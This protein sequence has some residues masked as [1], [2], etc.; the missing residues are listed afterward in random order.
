M[1]KYDLQLVRICR[2]DTLIVNINLILAKASAVNPLQKNE[3][4]YFLTLNRVKGFSE[5]FGTILN[6]SSFNF[7]YGTTSL[8]LMCICIKLRYSNTK[9][10]V[11]NQTLVTLDISVPNPVLDLSSPVLIAIVSEPST[12]DEDELGSSVNANQ[13]LS[14]SPRVCTTVEELENF[15]S[16]QINM[17]TPLHAHYQSLDS[18]RPHEHGHNG[19]EV[20]YFTG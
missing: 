6:D 9:L 14:T 5:S 18:P 3:K 7:T 13:T 4:K 1:I 10:Y 12:D 19:E 16:I 15:A 17:I 8:N 20:I 2:S 11:P